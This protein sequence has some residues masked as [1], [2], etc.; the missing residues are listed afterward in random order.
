MNHAKLTIKMH[1]ILYDEHVHLGL[2]MARCTSLA[3]HADI[4]VVKSKKCETDMGKFLYHSHLTCPY[5]MMLVRM[6]AHSPYGMLAVVATCKA[7]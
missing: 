4:S 5:A 1:A 3:W 7:A 2:T 6:H